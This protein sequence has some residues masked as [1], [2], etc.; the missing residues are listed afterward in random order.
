LQAVVEVKGR[1]WPGAPFV[2]LGG[3]FPCEAALFSLQPA[4][5]QL[6]NSFGFRWNFWL[7]P[8]PSFNPVVERLL[9]PRGDRCHLGRHDC[10]RFSDLTVASVMPKP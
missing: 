1:A 8:S 9:G 2:V 5:K 4:A 10:T 7:P 6:A 3:G